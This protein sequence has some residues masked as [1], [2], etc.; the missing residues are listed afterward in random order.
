MAC[1]NS[2]WKARLGFSCV[3]RKRLVASGIGELGLMAKHDFFVVVLVETGVDLRLDR[4]IG[5]CPQGLH[6]G[7]GGLLTLQVAG[8]DAVE[9]LAAMCEPVAQDARLF[10]AEY[11]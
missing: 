1:S 11:R 8:Y 10:D 9:A 4:L 7:C 6:A 3:A 5:F 2:C